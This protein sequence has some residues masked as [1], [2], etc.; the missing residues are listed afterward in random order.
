MVNDR[1]SSGASPLMAAMAP[2]K[3]TNMMQNYCRDLAEKEEVFAKSG[4]LKQ[5]M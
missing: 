3:A 5:G 4:Y 2:A 1:N